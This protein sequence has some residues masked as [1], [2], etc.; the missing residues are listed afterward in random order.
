MRT[1]KKVVSGLVVVCL[2][3]LPAY[4]AQKAGKGKRRGKRAAQVQVL[5][6]WLKDIQLTDEQKEKVEELVKEFGP[7]LA[8]LRKQQETILTPEQIQARK[9]ALQKAKEAG[10]KGR[11]LFKAGQEALKLTDE[12]KQKMEELRKKR[13]ELLRQLR[14]KLESFLTDEQKAKLPKLRGHGGKGARKGHGR[15]RGG[16]KKQTET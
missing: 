4:A 12:Q 2:L 16:K 11:E 10:K 9:E 7:K 13:M 6:Q 15:R 3:A 1:W 14:E 5:K 8:E